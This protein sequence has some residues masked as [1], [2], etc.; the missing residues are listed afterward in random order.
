MFGQGIEG[1]G[2]IRGELWDGCDE[3][4]IGAAKEISCQRIWEGYCQVSVHSIV[5]LYIKYIG[6]LPWVALRIRY[7]GIVDYSVY[8]RRE[9]PVKHKISKRNR[10]ERKREKESFF[11]I[12]RNIP[13]RNV[14]KKR[15]II[16]LGE[17]FL[18]LQNGT[19]M[20]Y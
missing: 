3:G 12:I 11:V 15:G 14:S 13:A 6:R 7:V 20:N 17:G 2:E 5:L 19:I 10:Q 16:P 1:I 9:K 8:S 4:G 18:C